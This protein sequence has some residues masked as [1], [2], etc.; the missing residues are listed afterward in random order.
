MPSLNF[1]R[2]NPTIDFDNSPF[3]VST[4][5]E[6]WE[7][8]S[9]PRRA[10]VSSFGFGGTNAHV[11]L[12][13]A[14]AA[15]VRETQ[16]DD[17]PSLVVLSGATEE[18][19]RES[20]DRMTRFLQQPDPPSLADIAYT[21]Q[22]GRRHFRHRMAV[23]ADSRRSLADSLRTWNPAPWTRDVGL[24][25]R[26]SGRGTVFL[27]TGQGPQHPGMGRQLFETCGVFRKHLEECA[28]ILG[29]HLDRPLLRRHVSG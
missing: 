27:F 9:K 15:A 20:V 14:P 3:F 8:G 16:N 2:A 12:E 7:T 17:L 5:L 6:P 19:L 18:A 4:R 28:E 10:G 1:E 26:D 22:V 29:P 25:T 24:G 23:A 21:S 13:E 11:V